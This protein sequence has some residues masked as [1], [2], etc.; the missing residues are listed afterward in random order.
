[1]INLE[2]AYDGI[3]ENF[4]DFVV[5][6]ICY[7]SVLVSPTAGVT[8]GANSLWAW[9]VEAGKPP[10]GHHDPCLNT[11]REAMMLPSGTQMGYLRKAFEMVDWWDLYPA[12]EMVV[13]QPGKNNIGRYVAIAAKRDRSAAI[14]YTPVPQDITLDLSDWNADL[15]GQWYDPQ[16]GTPGT[17]F[18]VT[19]GHD[20]T[21]S[22]P[23]KKDWVLIIHQ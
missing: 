1:V 3:R 20:V 15:K 21:L 17:L 4:D 13:D 9:A 14:A 10:L 2:P 12:P 11:W 18:D 19:A 16:T 5:R 8:Y 6:R 7:W 23:D 22:P